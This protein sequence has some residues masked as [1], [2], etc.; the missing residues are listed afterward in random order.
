MGKKKSAALIVLFTVVLVGLVFMSVASFPVSAVYNY[1]S[2]LSMID[3]ST[4]L[5][6]GVLSRRRYFAGRVQRACRRL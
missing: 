5:G 4:D 6:G 3:L 2:L 1:N